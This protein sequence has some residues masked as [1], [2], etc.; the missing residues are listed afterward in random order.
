MDDWRALANLQRDQLTERDAAI[1]SLQR[2]LRESQRASYDL[3]FQLLE[4]DEAVKRTT[5]VSTHTEASDELAKLQLQHDKLTEA[6]KHLN[7]KYTQVQAQL[8]ALTSS[9]QAAQAVRLQAQLRGKEAKVQALT[10]LNNHIVGQLQTEKLAKNKVQRTHAYNK[11]KCPHDQDDSETDLPRQAPTKKTFAAVTQIQSSHTASLGPEVPLGRLSLACPTTKG[12]ATPKRATQAAPPVSK[13]AASGKT[14]SKTTPNKAKP[15][16]PKKRKRISADDSGEDDGDEGYTDDVDMDDVDDEKI[17]EQ[18][19]RDLKRITT[20]LQPT[21]SKRR[22]PLRSTLAKPLKKSDIG[23]DFKMVTSYNADGSAQGFE[24]ADVADNLGELWERVNEVRDDI[25]EGAR[26]EQWQDI[27]LYDTD[28]SVQCVTKRLC[29]GQDVE[30]VKLSGGRTLWYPG[31]EGKY[32]C[33]D[34]VANDWP[35]FTYWKDEFWLLPLREEDRKVKVETDFE[36]RY[37]LNEEEDGSGED[38]PSRKRKVAKSP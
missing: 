1:D 3:R 28:K 12:K 20:R 32:A 25:W 9:G 7:K 2:Q 21:Q 14:K 17:D 31:H 38:A 27:F 37:W 33:R 4:Q 16:P 34:C 30:G 8:N 6:H 36:I 11:G 35:C 19:L 18:E 5:T 22:T 26:G 29:R 23:F 24:R 10:K 13:V 15:A